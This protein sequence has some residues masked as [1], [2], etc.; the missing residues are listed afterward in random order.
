MSWFCTPIRCPVI[1]GNIIL[2]HDKAHMTPP[3]ARF[4]APVLSDALTPI[5]RG[6]SD[7]LRSR[8]GK[9]RSTAA[10]GQSDVLAG[11]QRRQLTSNRGVAG[12]VPK[13]ANLT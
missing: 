6:V 9:G 11:W 2:Y 5:M 13:S 12:Y 10:S 8:E 3:W 7:E 4:L 1:V